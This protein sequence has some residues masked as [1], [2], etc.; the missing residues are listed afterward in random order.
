MNLTAKPKDSAI[1]PISKKEIEISKPL[2]VSAEK[3]I[4]VKPSYIKMSL[5]SSYAFS[6]DNTDLTIVLGDISGSMSGKGVEL[7]KAAFHNSLN[8]ALLSNTQISFAVWNT[9]T[10]WC[11][12]GKWITKENEHRTREW[13]NRINAAGGNNMHQ[14]ILVALQSLP[15]AKEILVMCDGDITPFYVGSEGESNN[16]N[17]RSFRE[18]YPNVRFNFVAVGQHASH[19]EMQKMASI[20]GG[21]YEETNSS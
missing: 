21:N 6:A 7:L 2:G 10:Y 18:Q 11:E 16:M 20:A 13:I 5:E 14:A 1:P 15:D 9:S 17:W 3:D 19:V 12:S 8:V 4:V